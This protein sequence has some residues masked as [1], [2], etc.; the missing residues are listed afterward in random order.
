[1]TQNAAVATTSEAQAL[2]QVDRVV[3]EIRTLM[4]HATLTHYEIGARL[5]WLKTNAPH[6]AFSRILEEQLEGSINPRQAQTLMMFARKCAGLPKFQAFAEGQFSKAALLLSNLNEDDLTALE[7]GGEIGAITLEAADSMSVREMRDE[8]KRLREVNKTAREEE[9][10]FH[11]AQIINL[12]KQ[13]ADLEE[14]LGESD[15][16]PDDSWIRERAGKINTAAQSLK[17]L[18]TELVSNKRMPEMVASMSV[19][20]RSTVEGSL[21]MSQRLVREAYRAFMVAFPPLED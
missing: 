20:H 6:G 14:T 10:N 8:I 3:G 9:R 15:D 18:V 2:V 7:S 12:E 16:P 4:M 13:V 19:P 17:S 11:R 1:M 5:L 21:A